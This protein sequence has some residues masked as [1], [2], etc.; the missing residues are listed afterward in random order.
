MELFAR[1]GGAHAAR[2]FQD[3]VA[4]RLRPRLRAGKDGRPRRA[5][6]GGRA[7]A[8]SQPRT[9]A[10]RSAMSTRLRLWQ[11]EDV[12]ILD[13][14]TRR[15]LELV[16]PLA[17]RRRRRPRCSARWTAPST[18][19][20]GRLLRQWLLAPLRDLAAIERRQSV[21]AWARANQ[22]ERGLLQER[23]RADPRPGA[24]RRAAGAGQ[25][26]RARPDRPARL[27]RATARAA[28]RAGDTPRRRAARTRR[29]ESRR[30]RNWP[31]FTR[32]R[33][34]TIRPSQLKEGGLI[35]A[36]YHAALEELRAASV[37]GQ[38]W[39]ADLQRREQER[40]GI[41]LA[42]GALQPGLRLLHRDQHGESRR[43]ARRLHAQADHGQRRALRHAR[44]EA[45]GIEN[46]RRAGT[47]AAAR[48][49]ALPR[50]AR[51]RRAAPAHDPGHRARAARDST[52]CSAGARWRRSAITSSPR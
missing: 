48:V 46:P 4:R 22:P 8:L 27:A 7:A 26:Q 51:R 3:R 17:A 49:R 6:R 18:A 37:E 33:W 30:C 38:E 28:R 13:A 5:Q 45:D 19:G 35:R 29:A 11:R 21:V 40:T 24:A 44:A 14:A 32:A 1:G 43:R 36:G 41:Q 20:G 34:P 31:T 16:D 12:L 42:Q 10:A 23:L 2:P 52:C 39:L 15:N 50:S 47:L 25:R 9:A